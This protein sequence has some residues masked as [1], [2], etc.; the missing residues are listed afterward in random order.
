MFVDNANSE[1]R[2]HVRQNQFLAVLVEELSEDVHPRELSF[3]VAVAIAM[4]GERGDEQWAR[5][6]LHSMTCMNKEEL[7]Q[8]KNV[9]GN[10]DLKV[11]F[12]LLDIDLLAESRRAGLCL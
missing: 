9:M 11:D 4:V 3:K 8:M 5:M 12:W 6:Y 10:R 2:E 1:F 7:G